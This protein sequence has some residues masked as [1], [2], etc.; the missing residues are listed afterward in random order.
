MNFYNEH[1]DGMTPEGA[2]ASAEIE[3]RI[4]NIVRV[5]ATAGNIFELESILSSAVWGCCAEFR[6][7]SGLDRRQAERDAR[8]TL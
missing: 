4:R 2:A 7:R 6:I 3:Q 8:S 5:Y 1:H